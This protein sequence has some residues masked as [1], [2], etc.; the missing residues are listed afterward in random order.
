MYPNSL[1]SYSGLSACLFASALL[2]FCPYIFN[3]PETFPFDDSIR[4]EEKFQDESCLLH[5]TMDLGTKG[6]EF[7]DLSFAE[8]FAHDD[9]G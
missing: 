7:L 6:G 2:S 1:I 3:A 4:G 8:R 5:H 9:H